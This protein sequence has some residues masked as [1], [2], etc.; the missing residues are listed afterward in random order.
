MRVSFGS[1]VSFFLAAASVSCGPGGNGPGTGFGDGGNGNGT[2]NG[3]GGGN[4]AGS[5][6]K[7]IPTVPGGPV[8]NP[9][10]QPTAPPDCMLEP[11]GPACGDGQINLTPPEACDDGNT[12][13]GDGCTGTCVV[14]PDYVCPTAG[15]P[16]V[17]TVV[18][19][20]GVRGR[21]E[22][23][24]DGNAMDGDG[25]AATCRIVEPGYV[26]RTPAMP[27]T[28]VHICGDSRVDS[29]E[30]CDDG[31]VMAGD[32]CSARCQIEIGWKCAGSPSTCTATTC[33][34]RII[35]GA[36][37]C[38]DGNTIGFDGC[39][40]NCRKEPTCSGPTAA[41]TSSCGDGIVLDEACDDGNLRSGDGCSSTCTVEDGFMCMNNAPCEMV[42]DICSMTVPAVFRD[43]NAN[44]ATGG[45]P[46]FAPGYNHDGATQGLVQ[47][48]LDNE[49]KPVLSSTA[50]ASNAFMHGTA[51]FAQWY[52]NAA[53][54]SAPVP[55]TIRLFDNGR[56]GFVNRWGAMG[57]QWRG[58]PQGTVNGMTYPNP[59]QCSNTDCADPNCAAPPAGMVCLN[60]CYPWNSTQACYAAEVL[61]DGNPMFF[62]LDP[63]R[64]GILNETRIPGKV[65]EQ[66]GWNGW[67]LETDVAT[68]LGFTAANPFLSATSPF[69]SA[70]HNFNFTT[71]VKYWF[72]YDSATSATLDFTGD[73][74]VWVF[75]NGRLTVDLGAWHVPLNGNVT[76]ANGMVTSTSYTTLTGAPVIASA[77]AAQFNLE[78]G[79]VYLISVFHAERE[80]DGSSFKLTLSG[81]NLVPSDC[82]TD[83][84]DGEIG[85]GEECDDGPNNLGG[86]NQCTADCRI[87]PHC[88]DAIQQE[89]GGEACDEGAAGNLGEYGVGCGPDCQPSPFCGDAI[90]QP[91]HEACDDG[92]NEITYGGCAPGCVLGPYCGDN[93]KQIMFEEC[94]DG[95]NTNMDGCSSACKLERPVTR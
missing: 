91:D 5:G 38:D 26:C 92:V 31:G 77:T 11:S 83:C 50:V 57:E 6:G 12:K 3:G 45:H 4:G 74:D 78:N 9:C 41:C 95:N 88:G 20:D 64:T 42:N 52:R 94:D 82:R 62:P 17:S 28:E 60:D 56:G 87:G 39:A 63:P 43:F 15:Q 30:G 59:L 47:A 70:T 67:P 80:K 21:G 73:D 37:S 35:E 22:A 8:A 65:P 32:G 69:P 75:L 16:C 93:M 51:Q 54:A 1:V 40:P 72:K 10:E 79:K 18:C 33:G 89:A 58:Y 25:C 84:G 24:D 29:N 2:G 55:G 14:E 23:C 49:G 85:A 53:P 48:T 13:P 71:E 76:I 44:G 34:D 46:D 68:R 90:V 27:C 7:S 86:Y 66:Y 36:E 81:F 19:G 61:Y